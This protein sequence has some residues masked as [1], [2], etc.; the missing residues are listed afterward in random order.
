M[1][2]V[3]LPSLLRRRTRRGAPLLYIVGLAVLWSPAPLPAQASHSNSATD[4]GRRLVQ[5]ALTLA[6]QGDTARAIDR[7]ARASRVAPDLAD[8]RFL[9]GL[10]LARTSSA[11]LAPFGGKRSD[12]NREFE[13][14]LRLDAGNPQY[15]IEVA[16]LKLKQ[17]YLRIQAERYFRRALD[18]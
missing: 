5:E 12:A 9:Y 4:E 1:A 2:P 17:P 10:L 6:E 11:G 15:L 13:A 8:A 16:R 18:A 14:A 7:A 3:P